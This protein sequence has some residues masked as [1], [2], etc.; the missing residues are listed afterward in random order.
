MKHSVIVEAK[1]QAQAA[2]IWLHGLGADGHDFEPLLPF[3]SSRL[4]DYCRFIFPHADKRPITI[5]GGMVM[6]AWYDIYGVDANSPQDAQGIAQSQQRLLALIQ[7]QIDAGIASERIVLAGFS[8]GGAI[9]LHTALR[10]PRRLAG[11]L[12]L[13]TYLPL[14]DTVAADYQ[15]VQQHLPVFL[16]HGRY[17]RVIPLASAQKA[18]QYLQ[19]THLRWFEYGMEHAICQQEIADINQFLLDCLT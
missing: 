15:A 14:V 16:A 7:T 19:H 6:P 9:A 18:R 10:Y 4:T 1:I 13:S 5:N 17:D 2:V 3:F 8:Q 12:A 11:V